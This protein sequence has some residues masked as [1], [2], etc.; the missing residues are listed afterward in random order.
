LDNQIEKAIGHF[1]L[2]RRSLSNQLQSPYWLAIAKYRSRFDLLKLMRFLRG[3]LEHE[4][5]NLDV[6]H[7]QAD[8]GRDRGDWELAITTERRLLVGAP[9]SSAA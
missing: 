1:E 7:A 2:A 9:T 8:F 6:L 4:P 5:E 3:V